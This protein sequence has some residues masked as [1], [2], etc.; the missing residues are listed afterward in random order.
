MQSVSSD[1]WSILTDL[2]IRSLEL[3]YPLSRIAIHSLDFNNRFL[4]LQFVNIQ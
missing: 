3:D 4:K 2:L 1:W